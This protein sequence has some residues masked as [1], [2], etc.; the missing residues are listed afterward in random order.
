[1]AALDELL[2]IMVQRGAE[3]AV[4]MSN[5]PS[6]I[7]VGGRQINGTTIA[8]LDLIDMVTGAAPPQ[9][10]SSLS[11]QG[12]FY[13]TYESAF[14]N[15]DILLER[16][17]R[18]LIALVEPAQPSKAH[19]AT[20]KIDALIQMMI[21][22]QA[23]RAVLINDRAIILFNG[24]L[25]EA[26][27][28]SLSLT[29]LK[30]IVAEVTPQ[31]AT[32][33]RTD[34]SRYLYHSSLGTYHIAAIDNGKR[35]RVTISDVPRQSAVAA[36]APE[37]SV[38]STNASIKDNP[39]NSLNSNDFG[40]PAVSNTALEA[41][42]TSLPTTTPSPIQPQ[43]QAFAQQPIWATWKAAIVGLVIVGAI[44]IYPAFQRAH[45]SSMIVTSQSNLKLLVL[46]YKQ[47]VEDYDERLPPMDNYSEFKNV[48]YPYVKNESYFVQPATQEPYQLNSRLSYLKEFRIDDLSNTVVIYEGTFG[49]DGRRGV[50]FADM[51]VSRVNET[52]WEQLKQVS[53]IP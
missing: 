36:T 3:R 17:G 5:R 22:H 41:P 8:H 53:G 30:A 4:L 6:Q 40:F 24:L 37:Q 25:E 14:G 45:N 49:T 35:L 38:A 7:F 39:S 16:G 42:S 9:L 13:F 27:E 34:T 2:K 21:Q 48:L 32:Q 51:M 50:A 11:H 23:N 43:T 29:Q 46:G 20:A 28:R 1:M 52:E 15:F 31:G 19:N 26:S 47:Y 10:H 12:K 33:D 18:T 44:V